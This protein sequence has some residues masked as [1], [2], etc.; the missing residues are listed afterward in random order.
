[1]SISNRGLGSVTVSLLRENLPYIPEDAERAFVMVG[2]NDISKGRQAEDVLIDYLALLDDLDALKVDIVVQSTLLTNNRKWNA[3]IDKVNMILSNTCQQGRC[4]FVDLNS[5][6]A[7]DGAIRPGM[8]YDGVHLNGRG[9]STWSRA[10]RPLM[11][12]DIDQSSN[13]G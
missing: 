13:P 6:L 12:T 9:Y 3:E 5:E 10:I 4:T 8:T 2:V 11:S 1:M 7:A